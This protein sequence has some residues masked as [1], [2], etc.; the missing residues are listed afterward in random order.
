M[1]VDLD[2]CIEY[3]F[4]MVGV[5]YYVYNGYISFTV[6]FRCAMT[7]DEWFRTLYTLFSHQ[8]LPPPPLFSFFF[9]VRNIIRRWISIPSALHSLSIAQSPIASTA[10]SHDQLFRSITQRSKRN[11]LRSYVNIC[12]SHDLNW[13][14]WPA[15]FV[16]LCITQLH[17]Y[18]QVLFIKHDIKVKRNV[19]K[20]GSTYWSRE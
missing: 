1:C 16:S 9:P 5:Y 19:R 15:L 17:M 6:L 10:L 11:L 18:E 20:R 8:R 12:S 4:K 14:E 7:G 3:K 2:I 13:F